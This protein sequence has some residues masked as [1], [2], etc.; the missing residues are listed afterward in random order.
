MYEE[1]LSTTE[2]VDSEASIPAT[3]EVEESVSP[4]TVETVIQDYPESENS[5]ESTP[6]ETVPMTTEPIYID[7]IESVGNDIV[8][9]SLF[10][11]FLIC[12][13]LVGLAL[14]RRIYGT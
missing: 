13:T 11:S 6:T 12:G 7:V 1:T 2:A 4:S 8:H 14:F 9:S 5:M 10:G 3:T